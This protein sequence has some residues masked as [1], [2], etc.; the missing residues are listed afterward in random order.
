MASELPAPTHLWQEIRR[1]I[2]DKKGEEAKY[3]IRS[4]ITSMVSVEFNLFG[5][6]RQRGYNKERH[7]P[8]SSISNVEGV[9]S[10][11]IRFPSYKNLFIAN[12]KSESAYTYTRN[13]GFEDCFED[14]DAAYTGK[15]EQK[16]K[17]APDATNVLPD[18]VRVCTLQLG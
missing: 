6:I 7:A 17:T 14:E 2:R 11:L 4:T 3:D 15:G 10:S 18:F 12:R 5:P 9:S 13:D 1:N 8:P 16:K